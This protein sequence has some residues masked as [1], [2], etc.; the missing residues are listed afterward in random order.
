M[1]T[2]SKIWKSAIAT[3]AVLTF[4]TVASAN[5]SMIFRNTTDRSVHFGIT[6]SD[7][8]YD[9]WT[10]APHGTKDLYCRNRSDRALVEIRTSH[11]DGDEVVHAVVHDHNTYLLHYD[12]D[13][14]VN[15]M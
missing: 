4:G 1:T 8:D 13:G 6:C 11:S 5:A 14:D 7:G 12:D 15:I 9:W 2:R 10:V 3:A